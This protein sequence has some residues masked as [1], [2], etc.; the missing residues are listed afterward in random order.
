MSHN[1]AN[2]SKTNCKTDI[3]KKQAMWSRLRRRFCAS[4]N[5]TE[6]RF[7]KTE[8]VRV[9]TEL[10]QWGKRWQNWGFGTCSWITKNFSVACFTGSKTNVGCK[11]VSSKCSTRKTYGRK[12]SYNATSSRYSVGRPKS[13]STNRT[14]S[15]AARKSYSAW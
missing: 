10:K 9:S 11:T 14:R 8:A 1:K 13:R 5:P 12:T 6:K 4:K 3:K 7:L 2:Y 15:S